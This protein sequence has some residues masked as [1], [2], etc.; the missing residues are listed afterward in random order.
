[1]NPDELIEIKRKA[2]V[3]ALKELWRDMDKMIDI[4]H[5]SMHLR[6][7]QSLIELGEDI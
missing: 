4:N 3:E 2:K 7:E 6:I 1:M 5:D